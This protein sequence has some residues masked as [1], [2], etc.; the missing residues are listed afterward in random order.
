MRRRHVLTLA[1]VG[2]VASGCSPDEPKS[3]RPAATP[4]PAAGEASTLG[5]GGLAFPAGFAW[6]ASTSAYQ[7]EGAAA[8]DG[9][10]PSVWDTFSHQ[11]GRTR[12]GDTGDVAA[13]HYH[14]VYEDLDLMKSLGLKSYRFSIS[15]SRVLPQGRGA[16]NAKGLDFYH[17]LVDGLLARGITPVATLFHWDTPQ[18]L[19]D[20]GG[21]EQRDCAQWFADYAQQMFYSL[22]D[23]V[24]TWLTL[25]EPKTVVALGYTT[26]THAPG[27]KD[28]RVANVAG[29]H[30]LLAHGLAVQAFRGTGRK[31]AI[32][33]ALNL[34]PVYPADGSA[35]AA[36]QA[37]A[38]DIEENRRWLEPVLLGK[39]PDGWL[40][41]QP[42]NAPIRAAV[43]DGD[44]AVIGS[45]ADL[46]AVQ[47][48]NPV[49]VTAQGGRVTKHPTTQAGWLEVYPDGLYDL[50]TR[51]KR[52][53]GDIPLTITENGMP[54]TNDV[55]D[56]DRIAFLRDHFRAAHKAVQAGVRLQGFHVWSLLD[57][58]EWA[59]GYS[60]RWG[61]IRVDATTR[62]RRYKASADWYRTVIAKN[63][64]DP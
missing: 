16:L 41:S 10:G 49:F 36:K 35:G 18:A 25:N 34:S 39:Y 33:A 28:R 48:Y 24:A 21:W 9:R 42:A 4:A 62:E 30:L 29:H 61:L 63:G 38:L 26:G 2:A 22:G 7:V 8:E 60:Q 53:Y 51:I 19:E 44:T 56:D 43:R 23:K 6:G 13:D 40:A 37:A 31:G 59:E 32:G 12:D 17:R 64:I 50:L 52:D 3:G 20:K 58:F 5:P 57:N 1:A 14:R 47:Y 46:L 55:Q 27:R 11:P 15:W 45:K 54:T